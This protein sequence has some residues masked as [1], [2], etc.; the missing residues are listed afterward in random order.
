[1][2]R[3][4]RERGKGSRGRRREGGREGGRGRRRRRGRRKE[5][6]MEKETGF[7]VQGEYKT[8]QATT[9]GDNVVKHAYH[10]NHLH[11]NIAHT[12]VRTRNMYLAI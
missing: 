1:M 12:F 11:P 5:G 3:R 2:E 10:M 8:N 6:E 9:R 4:G 7:T